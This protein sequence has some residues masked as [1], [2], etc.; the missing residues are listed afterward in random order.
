MADFERIAVLGLG[1]LGGSVA[2]AT[3]RAGVAT[4]TAG[5]TRNPEVLAEASR[6]GVVDD[7][8][9][10]EEVVRDADLVVLATTV[11]AMPDVVRLVA[12]CLREGA[13]VTDVGSVKG[14]LAESMPD[15]LPA[16]VCWVGAHPMAGS[17]ERGLVF[18]TADLFDG[19]PCI[20]TDDADAASVER[21]CEFWRALG[22]RV[23]RRDAT[24]HDEEVAWV[25][26][27][28][29]VLAYAYATALASA[30]AGTREV[31]GSGFRDFTRIARS[32][33]E[34]WGDILTANRQ[35]IAEPLR[36]VG[37]ALLSLG[38]VIEAGDAGKL[39]SLIDAARKSLELVLPPEKDQ[40]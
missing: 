17:H 4:R 31:V 38:E 33:P 40:S 37:S 8:G 18:A 13:I 23:V 35:S 3:K 10:F 7:V 5:A 28:P 20:V 2:L 21:V 24:A 14:V 32:S 29:H 30:P 15:L 9:S 25:S 39:E 27:V 16:G 26:H 19:K 11:A 6:R 36:A 34:L 1:L 22:A 12:P